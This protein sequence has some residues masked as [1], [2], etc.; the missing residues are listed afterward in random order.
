MGAAFHPIETHEAQLW[1]ERSWVGSSVVAEAMDVLVGKRFT[2]NLEAV[3]G[4]DLSLI[5]EVA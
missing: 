3:G 5:G 2:T 1:V 4:Y